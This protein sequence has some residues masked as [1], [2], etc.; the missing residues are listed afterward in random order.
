MSVRKDR[1][2][3][4]YGDHQFDYLYGLLSGFYKNTNYHIDVIEGARPANEVH[5]FYDDPYLSFKYFMGARRKTN[6]GKALRWLKYYLKLIPYLLFNSSKI[7]HIEWVN[8]QF[9][10]FEEIML[11]F[12][13]KKI[14]SQKLVYKVH[15]ISSRLLLQKPGKDYK[16]KLNF[17]KRFFYKNVDV[18]IV[19]NNYTKNLL[20]NFGIP[21]DKIEIIKHGVN[22]FVPYTNLKKYEARDRLQLGQNAKIVLFFGNISPYKNIE[23]LID[24]LAQVKKVHPEILL[25]IAGNYRKGLGDYK[26]Q[27]ESKLD[28]EVIKDNISI[29]L[30]F[31]ANEDIET[32]FAA[33]D[34]LCLP[35]K[36]IFQ[37]G[38]LF[39]ANTLGTFVIAR[40]VGGIPEDIYPGKTGM[41][42]LDDAQLP[43]I[44]TSFFESDQYYNYD[45]RQQIR[46]FANES[47]S[48]VQ[49]CKQL[50]KVYETL[51]N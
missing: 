48:W 8:S 28:N 11:P 10:G 18:F 17:T 6:I 1:I 49:L 46:S 23:S 33:A 32:Y 37:S 9:V 31:I 15:D 51:A 38:V 25:L 30:K 20:S 41:T 45:F 5:S 36:F 29:H 47:Y 16:I 27:I 7:I 39:L 14:R 2:S 3:L 34:V 43:D 12:I 40:E 21:S 44:L 50:T 42:Y 13:I 19:H 4:I 24:A 26:T 22:N 35:Y